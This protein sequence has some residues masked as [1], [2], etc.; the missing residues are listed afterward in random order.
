MAV[1]F[2]YCYRRNFHPSYTLNVLDLLINRGELHNYTLLYR[3]V[4]ERGNRQLKS[5]ED[6]EE[7]LM[8]L[9]SWKQ[10]EVNINSVLITNSRLLL[11]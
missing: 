1:M 4:Y 6:K 3:S 9:E 7:R 11:R 2:L 5:A 8:L 10:F